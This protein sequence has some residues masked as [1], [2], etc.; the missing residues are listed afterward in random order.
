MS[1][2]V[3]GLIEAEE[4]AVIDTQLI[5]QGMMQERGI[6]RAQLG[7]RTGIGDAQLTRTVMCSEADPSLRTLTRIAHALGCRLV[8]S[9]VPTQ[10]EPGEQ[11]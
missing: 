9:L 8:V 11:P 5:I 3:Q 10:P 6:T 2:L 4:D 7:L 1:G